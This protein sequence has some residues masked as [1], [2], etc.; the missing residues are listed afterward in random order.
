MSSIVKVKLQHGQHSIEVEGSYEEA[1]K[2]LERY[3]ASEP[4]DAGSGH[5]K[6]E[7]KPPTKKAVRPKQQANGEAAAPKVDANEWANTIKDDP[8]FDTFQ[9]K[10]LHQKDVYN[11]LAFV[12][13]YI[14]ESIHL[15][16]GDIHRI[17]E[18]L[19]VKLSLPAI[20]TCLSKNSTK[21]LTAAEKG[22]GHS[23]LYKLVSKARKE[24][25]EFVGE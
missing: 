3:W 18:L 4:I 1:T 13:W 11:K 17:L 7:A 5:G 8:R 14:G 25:G 15:S 22:P 23:T 10:V 19:G 6:G 2:L 24:F 16:S 21:F 9:T 12:A 20:S